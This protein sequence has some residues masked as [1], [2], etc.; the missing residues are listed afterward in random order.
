VGG[1]VFF[2]IKGVPEELKE[3]FSK[4]RA[5]MEALAERKYGSAKAA[6]GQDMAKI[7]K[8]TRKS[9]LER[10][11]AELF[12]TWQAIAAEYG[13]TAD[14]IEKMRQPVQA[15]TPPQ[16]EELKNRVFHDAISRLEASHALTVLPASAIPVSDHSWQ[17]RPSATIASAPAPFSSHQL[18]F[19][20][21]TAAL[22][23]LSQN[24]PRLSTCC[25]LT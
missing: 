8:E 6:R 17:R 21:H 20:Q 18:P 3:F 16:R 15:L 13:I 2:D 23:Q 12:H 22:S 5:Q 19:R 4:R 25:E 1:H 14:L 11:S 7:N 9:K 24:P 10:P